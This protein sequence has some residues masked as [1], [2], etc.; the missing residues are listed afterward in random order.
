MTQTTPRE[1]KHSLPKGYVHPQ[2]WDRQA[3]HASRAPQPLPH[4]SMKLSSVALPQRRDAVSG[5][6]VEPGLASGH[7]QQQGHRR[8]ADLGPVPRCQSVSVARKITPT[9][10]FLRADQKVAALVEVEDGHHVPD[11]VVR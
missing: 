8:P 1:G 7:G 3:P 11:R 4:R 10:Q 5:Q 2:A 6:I 9:I